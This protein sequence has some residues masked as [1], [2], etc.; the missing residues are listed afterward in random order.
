MPDH[1]E[2]ELKTIHFAAGQISLY[3]LK[4]ARD[5]EFTDQQ[6]VHIFS[7]LLEFILL[8]G[9]Q[10][11]FHSCIQPENITLVQVQCDNRYLAKVIEFDELS[12]GELVQNSFTPNYFLNP[13]KEYE[14]D[15]KN[16]MIFK[17][18]EDR[19]KNE[20]FTIVRTMQRLMT[21]ESRVS[22]DFTIQKDLMASNKEQYLDKMR[23]F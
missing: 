18:I 3:T 1:F 8:L 15:S 23:D 14:Y 13:M 22:K 16:I 7:R 4:G 17:N 21:K 9:E 5:F 19:L 6:L 2:D 10:K 11:Y 20:F 12:K